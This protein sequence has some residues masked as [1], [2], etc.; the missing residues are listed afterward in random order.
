M[1][2]RFVGIPLIHSVSFAHAKMVTRG[3]TPLVL[4]ILNKKD[5]NYIFS[6]DLRDSEVKAQNSQNQTE[7]NREQTDTS[8]GLPE[9]S[10]EQPEKSEEKTE[11]SP[12]PR[13]LKRVIKIGTDAVRMI[14]E[15]AS[16]II[17]K[18]PEACL[19]CPRRFKDAVPF[20][21]QT[22]NEEK[23]KL[24]LIDSKIKEKYPNYRSQLHVE[25]DD[26]FGSL[27]RPNVD[28]DILRQKAELQVDIPRGYRLISAL[29]DEKSALEELFAD[30]SRTDVFWDLLLTAK[31]REEIG[32]ISN[33][34]ASEESKEQFSLLLAEETKREL[35]EGILDTPF[36]DRSRFGPRKMFESF[37]EMADDEE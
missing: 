25:S 24:E 6:L 21:D 1:M 12:E 32:G 17:E 28:T 9:N 33:Q 14:G 11:K 27:E 35:L 22:K 29:S 4:P 20:L 30:D 23:R 16:E 13:G 10:P 37:R 18:I 2:A 5:P 26:R 19:S 15:T 7:N 34:V 8:Q 3:S 36:A 31:E